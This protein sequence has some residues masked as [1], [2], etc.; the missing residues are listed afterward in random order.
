[1]IAGA[2]IGS[3]ASAEVEMFGF[4]I[5]QHFEAAA[6]GIYIKYNNYS[7]SAEDAFGGGFAGDDVSLNDFST[8]YTGA[9]IQF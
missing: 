3:I 1:M 2:G 4:G 8:I 7:A 9:R 6:L 5:N